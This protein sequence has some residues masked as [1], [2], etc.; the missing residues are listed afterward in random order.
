MV[1]MLGYTLEEGIGRPIWGFISEESK[2]IVKMNLEKRRQEISESYELK[3]MCENGSSLWTF[4]NA[5]PLSDKDGK[6]IGVM[7]MFTDITKRKE[8][9]EALA[10]I[11]IA[12]KKEIHHRIKNNLQVI[13]SLLDL[14]ADKFKNREDIKD[15]EVLEAFRESKDRVI[16]MALIH[17]ELHKGGGLDTLNFSSYIEELA[18]NLFL[19]YRLG[20][21]NIGLN[22]ELEENIFLDMDIAVPLGI[23]V[24]ELVSN[25]FKHAFP[26][27]D[28]GEIRITLHREEKGKCVKDRECIQ[29]GEHVNVSEDSK[30][31]GCQSTDFILTVS[32]NGVG[33]PEYLDVEYLDVEY[34]DSLGLQL[35]ASLVEQLDGKLELKRNEGTEFTIRFT[36]TARS[37]QISEPLKQHLN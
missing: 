31:G 18:E 7:S 23:I 12:R 14:Q 15:S 30:N 35:V 1:D 3:L 17:E 4:I 26:G 37:K 11:E 36:V 16:S 28:K 32:D 20:D 8:A 24:N 2:P 33:I 19:T 25:S 27:E 9:E 10:N 22:L 21:K 34:L 29:K 13:T 6:Y 5:K